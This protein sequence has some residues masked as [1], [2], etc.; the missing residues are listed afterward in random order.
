VLGRF[1]HRHVL[2][3]RGVRDVL[4]VELHRLAAA[5]E[6]AGAAVQNFDDVAAQL[7]FVNL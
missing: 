5:H 4:L 2:L 1:A 3:D 6:L 7:A